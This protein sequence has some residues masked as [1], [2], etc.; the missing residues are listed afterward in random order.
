MLPLKI[1]KKYIVELLQYGMQF[2]YVYMSKLQQ[3]SIKELN[4]MLSIC[5]F[6]KGGGLS[7]TS[8]E[9]KGF[10]L[11]SKLGGYILY[12]KAISTNSTM[13]YSAVIFTFH[14]WIIFT[15]HLILSEL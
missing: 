9:S 6:H 12:P 7:S 14:Y 11:S 2:H 5:H 3:M 13:Q 1:N 10:T 15:W 8:K 4:T